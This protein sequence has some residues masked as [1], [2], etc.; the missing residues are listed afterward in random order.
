MTLIVKGGGGKQDIQMLNRAPGSQ[1]HAHLTPNGLLAGKGF[2]DGAPYEAGLTERAVPSSRGHI[3][4]MKAVENVPA[5]LAENAAAPNAEEG[6]GSRVVIQNGH[7]FIHQKHKK[8]SR[9]QQLAEQ[10]FVAHLRD[11][12]SVAEG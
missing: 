4:G 10:E 7:V 1:L 8:E 6:S 11:R 12:K 3:P 2:V 9:V 5:A